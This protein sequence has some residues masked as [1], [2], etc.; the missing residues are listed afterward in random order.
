MT[1]KPLFTAA[2]N[3]K[4]EAAVHSTVARLTE[5]AEKEG[6]SAMLAE[7]I[8]MSWGVAHVFKTLGLKEVHRQLRK[9][10]ADFIGGK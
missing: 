10:L 8:G 9:D 4:N 1:E 2:D 7:A 5:I 6:I 3:A